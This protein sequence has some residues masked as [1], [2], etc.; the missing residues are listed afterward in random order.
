MLKS[1]SLE[2]PDKSQR[3][4]IVQNVL[5]GSKVVATEMTFRAFNMRLYGN[6]EKDVLQKILLLFFFSLCGLKDQS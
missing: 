3:R 4:N 2:A 1:L 6:M 5:A